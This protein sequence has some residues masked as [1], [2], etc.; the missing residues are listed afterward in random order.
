MM[1]AN[2]GFPKSEFEQ[3][4]LRLQTVMLEQNL[5]AIVLT[6]EPHVRYFSGFFTQF[7]RSPTRPWFLVVPLEGKPIAVIPGIGV[8][9]MEQTWIDDIRSWAAPNPDDDGVSLLAAAC[10]DLP[11]RF[12]RVGFTLGLQSMLRMP[13]ND[14]NKL[15]DQLNNF[16]IIDI[17]LLM[18]NLL[19]V[20]S[21]LEIEKIRYVCEITADGFNAL[22]DKISIGET[23]RQI[24]KKLRIDLLNLGADDIPYMVAGSGQD[25]YD[26]IIMGPTDKIISDGEVLI[27][28]TGTVFDGYFSDFDRNYGFGQ[29]EE[30]SRQAYRDVYAATEAGL[31][32]A[33][34]GVPLSELFDAMW[35]VL[36]DAGAQASDVGRMGHGLGMQL[37]EWPSITATDETITQ[38]G[39][40]LTLEP[41]MSFAPGKQMVHEENIVI[42]E[43]GCELLS[44]RAWPEMPIID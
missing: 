38:P 6:T 18:H 43:S 9:G 11:K 31:R 22:P 26:S 19:S 35:A 7:W 12:G 40:V 2:R 29:V 42:T 20:K 32:T 17:A 3:R 44:K 16:A 24:S 27:I 36:E 30:K 13:V 5:D 33:R 10:N 21:E 25:S 23:E 37:T 39:M 8:S 14:Y 28:D 15:I 41:A 34:P 4:T 1:S